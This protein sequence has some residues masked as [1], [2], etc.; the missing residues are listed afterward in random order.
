MGISQLNP[1]QENVELL[2][3]RLKELY[4]TTM[5][6][7]PRLNVETAKEIRAIKKELGDMGLEVTVKFSVS[8]L[9]DLPNAKVTADIGIWIPKNTTI[10]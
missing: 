7:D 2:R 1:D 10:Q 9:E 8:N 4:E 3:V 5:L 6:R